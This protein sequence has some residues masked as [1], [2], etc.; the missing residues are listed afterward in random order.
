M[1]DGQARKE[2][3]SLRSEVRSLRSE[4]HEWEASS[5]TSCV[6]RGEHDY[7]QKQFQAVLK[8]FGIEL[9]NPGIVVKEYAK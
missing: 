8:H 9:T 1:R 5:I 6:T 3:A 7:L 2:I 4:F